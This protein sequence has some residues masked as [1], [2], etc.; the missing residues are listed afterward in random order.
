MFCT[1]RRNEETKRSV[2]SSTK[3]GREKEVET[4]DEMIKNHLL[5]TLLED[6]LLDGILRHELEDQDLEREVKEAEGELS[7]PLEGRKRKRA[8]LLLLSEPVSSGDG[9]KIL[10]RL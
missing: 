2:Y 10:M 8:Y 7:S 4:H 6:L 9:L 3:G 5:S 1:W